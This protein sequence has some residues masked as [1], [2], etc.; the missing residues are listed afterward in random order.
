MDKK[1]KIAHDVISDEKSKR[2]I[3]KQSQ[4]LSSGE[5]VYF[6]LM[7]KISDLL[8]PVFN[9]NKVTYSKRYGDMFIKSEL[10]RFKFTINEID[11]PKQFI[12][13]VS[14]K[15]KKNFNVKQVSYISEEFTILLIWM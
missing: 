10:I 4:Y 7:K 2:K 3:L 9:N 8:K 11:N 6:E 5:P 12:Q 1:I 15:L 13:E 14:N